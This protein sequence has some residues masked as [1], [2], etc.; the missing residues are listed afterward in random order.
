M[1]TLLSW[2]TWSEEHSP[3]GIA[4]GILLML[5]AAIAASIIGNAL[6]A[7]PASAAI[8]NVCPVPTG[9]V[10][11][12]IDVCTDRGDD[13]TYKAGDQIT[14][15]VSA[16]IPQIMIYPP[17]PPPT[18]L[19]EDVLADGSTRPLI[20][21]RMASGQQCVAGTVIEPFGQETVRARALGQDGKV[22]QEDTAQISTVPR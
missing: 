19:V 4:T 15:C 21:A 1:R 2:I 20:E 7:T 6:I 14:V 12:A 8:G 11:N 5:L 16:N 18:I 10:A 17:P 9:Q 3:G 22:I 13:A